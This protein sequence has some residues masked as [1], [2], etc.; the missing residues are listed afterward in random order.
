[1]INRLGFNSEG[2][3]AVAQ[4]LAAR[5][6]A[7]GIVGINIGA[8]K[9]TVDRAADYVTCI[10]ALAPHVELSHRQHLLAQHGRACATCSRRARSTICW[11]A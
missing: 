6:G 1:M 10:E 5:A 9:D 7:P 3:E 2:V 4:R 8:N 11:R